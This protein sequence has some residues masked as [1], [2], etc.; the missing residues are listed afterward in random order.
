MQTPA[1]IAF[2]GVDTIDAL[3]GMQALSTRYPIEWGILIDDAQSH[4]PLFPDAATRGQMLR[5]GALRWA[6]HVCGDEARTIVNTPLASRLDLSGFQRVQLNHSFTGSTPQH[7]ENAHRFGQL[8]GVRT[9]L[10]CADP[11]P[12]DVR[13]DWLYDVSFGEGVKPKTW[14]RLPQSPAFCGYSGGIGPATVTDIL[15]HINAPEGAQYWIDMESGI[16]TDGWLDLTKCE[17]VCRAVFG[18]RA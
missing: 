2:T 5:A 12:E 9:L 4:K 14:P 6:A 18:E 8:R 16:R 1:F 15:G 3:T 10:Q 11:F 13:V 7:I 17:A